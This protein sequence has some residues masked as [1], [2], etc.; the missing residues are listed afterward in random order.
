MCLNLE[1]EELIHIEN[2]TKEFKYEFLSSYIP[3]W[4][5]IICGRGRR[6]R[7]IVETHAG[8][9]YVE[10]KG[11]EVFGSSIIF[12]QKTALK[13]E[14]LDFYF[15]EK[16]KTRFRALKENLNK[17]SKQGFYFSGDIGKKK[18]IGLMK[19]GI[20]VVKEVP[21]YPSTTKYPKL[22]QIHLYKANSIDV[23]DEILKEIEG[24][25]SFIF[26]D[27]CG[28]SD[29]IIIEKIINNRLIEKDGSVKL[30]ERGEKLQGT[31]LLINFSWE[32]ILRN[33]SNKFPFEQRNKFFE[34]MYGMGLNQ[35]LNDIKEVEKKFKAFRKRYS[36]FDL[37][38]QLYIN[39][40]RKYFK[41]VSKLIILGLKSIKNPVY[42]LIFC[43]NNDSAKTLFQGIEAILNKKKRGY[44]LLRKIAENK[45]D[46]TM[47]KYNEIIEGNRKLDEFF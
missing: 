13:Q 47:D 8:S 24:K 18:L 43:T 45:K 33:N 4:N 44:I 16:D 35:V 32:A 31:E 2:K 27:P 30:D 39:N 34:D 36:E 19:N 23:I 14:A 40:L 11:K 41:F 17:I 15:V 22:E 3:M 10:L 25:P 28:K 42:A 38:I 1:N 5:K 9:G 12:L 29:W 37:Y 20:P 46:F 21:N 6:Y 7:A 26:I